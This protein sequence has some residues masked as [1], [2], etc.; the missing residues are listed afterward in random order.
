MAHPK[1][2]RRHANPDFRH[3][4]PIP[5]PPVAEIEQQ[6]WELLSPALLAPRRLERPDP[7]QPQR[8]LRRRARLLTLPV[9]VAMLVSLVWR[10]L[11]AVAA[12]C[13]V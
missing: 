4:I 11:A 12:V 10:R 6:L 8:P 3:R 13:R 7:R 5:V 1:K 2:A 9:M